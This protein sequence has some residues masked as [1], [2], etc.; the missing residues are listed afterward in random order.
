MGPLLVG[1]LV[2]KGSALL[3]GALHKMWPNVFGGSGQELAAKLDATVIKMQY[4]Q[5]KSSPYMFFLWKTK[6]AANFVKDK[7][8]PSIIG[9]VT[10]AVYNEHKN[11]AKPWLDNQN[12]AYYP[13]VDAYY[14][15]GVE[16]AVK[17]QQKALDASNDKNEP[18]TLQGVSD[19]SISNN[20]NLT[21]AAIA[22]IAI[23][24]YKWIR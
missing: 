7:V 21:I 20:K 18:L 17:V 2:L 1:S 9:S 19:A 5:S 4:E 23:I 12:W 10:E 8:P 22:V 15:G 24:L 6:D 3:N 16:N 14:N 11:Q 13:Y